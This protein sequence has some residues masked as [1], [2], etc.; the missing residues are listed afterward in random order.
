[1]QL[2][3]KQVKFKFQPTS[4]N[5]IVKNAFEKYL[6]DVATANQK[7][8]MKVCP[9]S[10]KQKAMVSVDIHKIDR[11]YANLINNA[12]RYTSAGGTIT[13]AAELEGNDV[14]FKVSDTGIGI[15]AADLPHVFDRFYMGSKS[16]SSMSGN[17]GLGLSIAK[18]IIE[19]H[20]GTIWVESEL[21]K[22]TTFFFRL[23]VA[24]N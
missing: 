18:E 14:V 6:I 24:S 2:E 5:D 9:N 3:T 7:L 15:N 4:V 11:V 20:Q 23:P 16:R 21:D 12:I 10:A 1:M 19:A 8:D 13:L 17:S 22:G